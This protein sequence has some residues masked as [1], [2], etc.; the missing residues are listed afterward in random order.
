MDTNE[1][2]CK[3]NKLLD[4]AVSHG[5]DAGGP[6]LSNNFGLIEAL[7]ELIDFLGLK[8]QIEIRHFFVNECWEEKFVSNVR[9]QVVESEEK[10]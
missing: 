3:F 10:I 5:G 2:V 1:L 6:Y 8:D 4:A 7:E 9:V